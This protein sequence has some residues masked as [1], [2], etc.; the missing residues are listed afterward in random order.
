MRLFLFSFFFLLLPIE[1]W[2]ENSKLV[3]VDLDVNSTEIIKADL[4]QEELSY[5]VD[6]NACVCWVANNDKQ[7]SYAAA[8]P[9]K[10]LK[11]HEKLKPYLEKCE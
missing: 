3:E 6:K 11:A 2:A 8:L 5:Y 7:K 10:A 1:S 9:C 4:D